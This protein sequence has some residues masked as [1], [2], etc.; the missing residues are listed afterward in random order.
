MADR[1][2]TPTSLLGVKELELD[3]SL[4]SVDRCRIVGSVLAGMILRSRLRTRTAAEGHM[5]APGAINWVS[6]LDR[7]SSRRNLGN[8][9]YETIF[10]LERCT[11]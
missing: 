2:T 7:Q 4:Y 3:V 6:C 9:K 11:Y 10:P 5:Q 1:T 8:V